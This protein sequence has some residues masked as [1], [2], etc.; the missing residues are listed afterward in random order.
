MKALRHI[1]GALILSAAFA[2]ISHAQNTSTPKIG[3]IH[4]RQAIVSTA[5]GR[6]ASA[7]IDAEFSARRKELESLS[8][9]IEE[10][11]QRL[12]SGANTLGDEEKER[13]TVRG[14][15]LSQQLERK[16][17]E[18]QE[19]LNNAQSDAIA[20]INRKLLGLV[21]E[22]A[23]KNGFSAVLDDSAPN[24]PVLYAATDIT[25][26]IVRLYDQTYPVKEGT[27][28]A[29]KQPATKPSGR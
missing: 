27:S 19:D 25:A 15:R 29:N 2:T 16:Q 11:R 8:K 24:T 28:P 9:Q 4:L 18:F 23:P 10:I 6:K 22:Y 7:Q 26:D 14:Q 5:E 13:L 21:S 1:C 3:A 12:S 17:N 20:G